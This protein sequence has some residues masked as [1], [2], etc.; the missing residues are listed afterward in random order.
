MYNHSGEVIAEV[1]T[2]VLLEMGII[3]KLGYFIADN[4]ESNNTYIRALLEQ[5]RPNIRYPDARRTRCLNYIINLV[6]K[7]LLF[8]K[9]T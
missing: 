7:A 8:G 5:L 4:V 9:D 2:P 6:T 3:S 1:I